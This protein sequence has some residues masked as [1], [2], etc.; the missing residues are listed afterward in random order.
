MWHRQSDENLY[1]AD[2]VHQA[3]IE[4]NEEGAEAA[5]ATA[6]IVSVYS[7]VGSG[8]TVFKADH[9]FI[10]FIIDNRTDMILFSGKVED[11]TS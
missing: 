5:A 11:P 4:V 3:F 8:P 6:V 2:V 9:P 10:F 7:S 1:I